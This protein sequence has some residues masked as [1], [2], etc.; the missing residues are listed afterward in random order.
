M[1]ARKPLVEASNAI[2][3]S[4]RGILRAHGIKLPER[5]DGES[6]ADR[7]KEA[8]KPLAKSVQAAIEELL[9]AWELL[10]SQQQRMYRQLQDQLKSDP[11]AERLMTI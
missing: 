1:T 8:M 3:S 6:F 7:V 10:H 9:Q 5:G 4:V 11:V 2:A